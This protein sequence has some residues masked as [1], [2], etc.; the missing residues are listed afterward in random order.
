M[1]IMAINKYDN[2]GCESIIKLFSHPA[3]LLLQYTATIFSSECN[4]NMYISSSIVLIHFF[5]FPFPF[6]KYNQTL[7]VVFFFN[8]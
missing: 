2:H 3:M 7:V 4:V 1:I 6:I 8:K 5:L